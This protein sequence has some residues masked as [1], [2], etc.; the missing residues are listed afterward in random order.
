MTEDLNAAGY[1]QEARLISDQQEQAR[2]QDQHLRRLFTDFDTF[3][4]LWDN[5][6]M[7]PIMA[8]ALDPEQ[9]KAAMAGLSYVSALTGKPER[10]IA[11]DYPLL[12]DQIAKHQ[13]T[14]AEDWCL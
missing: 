10:E 6:R 1:E 8:N 14:R 3:G 12:R 4:G 2:S 9:D 13:V 5:E 11:R 7:K